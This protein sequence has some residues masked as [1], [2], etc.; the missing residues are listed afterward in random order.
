MCSRDECAP[1]E[2]LPNFTHRAISTPHQTTM[3]SLKS[4]RKV[5]QYSV[6]D[7]K[8][9]ANQQ[10]AWPVAHATLTEVVRQQLQIYAK[11]TSA[12]SD[13]GLRDTVILSSPIVL[14]T[15]ITL[16]EFALIAQGERQTDIV[17][18]GGPTELD[19]L[20]GIAHDLPP[21][22][23]RNNPKL[24]NAGRAHT[25]PRLA[26][27]RRVKRIRRWTPAW[28]IPR[29]M[30][31][32]DATAVMSG[33]LLDQTA[34]ESD[35]AVDFNYAGAFASLDGGY[36][37]I[38]TSNPSVDAL[39]HSIADDL[40]SVPSLEND[41]SQRLNELIRR[42]ITAIFRKAASDL[43]IFGRARTMPNRLWSI[44]AGAYPIRA[45]ALA[46][47]RRG[48]EVTLFAHGGPQALADM[49]EILAI[50][51]LSAATKYVAATDALARIIEHSEAPGMV[52]SFRDIS[53]SGA[54]GDA[55]MA[56]A[57]IGDRTRATARRRVVYAPTI[58]RGRSPQRT[59]P[60]LPDTI[61]NDWQC[62][63]ATALNRMPV[64]FLCKPHPEGALQGRPQ[65]LAAIAET[66][67]TPFEDNMAAADVFVFDYP[68]STT[69]WLAL[70][71]DRPIVV[72]DLGI[73]GFADVISSEIQARC[74][75]IKVEFDEMNRPIVNTEALAEAVSGGKT[76]IDPSFFRRLFCGEERIS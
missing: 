26:L 61:Y 69:F 25:P 18:D 53:F 7:Q 13:L 5:V 39:C 27:L 54:G 24:L 58:L 70:C 55:T 73:V 45:L 62:R 64:D 12:L 65:P 42:E 2:G 51:E 22:T 37:A 21:A 59:P 72:L 32:P 9:E 57:P 36:Q 44:G 14:S 19:Y 38:E 34:Q 33:G 31:R 76:H 35:F 75:I 40:S 3:T 6:L 60:L 74:Q 71:S 11:R 46:V 41:I 43:D 8:V 66:V 52:A 16:S 4:R 15:T 29:A 56:R 30:I 68:R 50:I 28:R 10:T 48:G 17:V 67:M 20:R 1:E 23:W 49:H 63:V 47:L